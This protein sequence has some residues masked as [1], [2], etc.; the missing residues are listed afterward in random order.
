MVLKSSIHTSD[1]PW[2]HRSD[3]G[4]RVTQDAYFS[5][6]THTKQ[7]LLV[8]FCDTIAG[9]GTVTGQDGTMPGGRTDVNVEIVM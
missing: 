9:I 2:W 7:P 6:L 1:L 3:W 8:T 5:L 4:V